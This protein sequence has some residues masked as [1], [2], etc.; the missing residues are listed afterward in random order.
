VYCGGEQRG[1][2]LA[3]T[4]SPVSSLRAR[5]KEVTLHTGSRGTLPF[6]PNHQVAAIISFA[7]QRHLACSASISSYTFLLAEQQRPRFSALSP[8]GFG[9]L[10]LAGRHSTWSDPVSPPATARSCRSDE[11]CVGDHCCCPALPAL[12]HPARLEWKRRCRAEAS[13][14]PFRDVAC[15]HCSQEEEHTRFLA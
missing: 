12:P 15:A 11:R 6:L 14:G 4:S 7:L 8:R 10:R 1:S 3:R 5:T 2:F 13:P 9:H